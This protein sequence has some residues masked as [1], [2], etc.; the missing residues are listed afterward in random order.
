MYEKIMEALENKMQKMAGADSE[1][2]ENFEKMAEA[3]GCL[4]D[5]GAGIVNTEEAATYR[6]ALRHALKAMLC[7]VDC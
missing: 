6:S 2:A 3:F 4:L 7:M 1:V 5:E